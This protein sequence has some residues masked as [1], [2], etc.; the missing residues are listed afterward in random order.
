MNI[1]DDDAGWT[2]FDNNITTYGEIINGDT[3]WDGS[4]KNEFFT[5]NNDNIFRSLTEER[6]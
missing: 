3:D 6:V 1:I 4:V 5:I 2:C